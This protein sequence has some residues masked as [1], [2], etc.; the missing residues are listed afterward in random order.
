MIPVNQ[1]SRDGIRGLDEARLRSQVL[2]PL[3]EAMGFKGIHEYHGGSGEQGKDIIM[4]KEDELGERVY[5]GVV[6]LAERI[7]GKARG[8]TSPASKVEFQVRQSIGSSFQDLLTLK[9]QQIDRCWVVTSGEVKKEARESLNNSLGDPLRRLIRLIDGDELW[10]LVERYL[11]PHLLRSKIEEAH[12]IL[13]SVSDHYHI[14]AEV[15]GAVPVY[16]IRP[17]Y[18]GA[19]KKVPIIF[20]PQFEFP[21]TPE[22][23]EAYG[24]LKEHFRTGT[25]I[26]IAGKYISSFEVSDFLKPLMDPQGAGLHEL[27]MRYAGPSHTVSCEAVFEMP[28]GSVVSLP[29][30]ELQLTQAGSEEVTLS[31]AH[32]DLPYKFTI[33]VDTLRS[34]AA[35]TASL[36]PSGENVKQ[37]LEVVRFHQ[38]IAHGGNLRFIHLQT[39]QTLLGGPVAPQ[40]IAGPDEGLIEALEQLLIIQQRTSQLFSLP[41][42]I[43]AEEIE[44]IVSF[45]QIVSTGELTWE[46]G[47]TLAFQGNRELA[48]NTLAHCD[49]DPNSLFY[50]KGQDPREEEFFGSVLDLGRSVLRA[51]GVFVPEEEAVRLRAELADPTKKLFIIRVQV[52]ARTRLTLSYPK[53]LPELERQ[54]L[55]STFDI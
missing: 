32:Q 41:P 9:T 39:G 17:K 1:F 48:A 31:N 42:A 46:D 26:T 18:A 27:R 36:R 33:T 14:V 11:K 34:H 4:W 49:G 44:R 8:G 19:E 13:G 40:T 37:Q 21:D 38:A 20:R 53:W 52:P 51:Y 5:Y 35:L 15:G 47:V 2:I 6:V 29:G 43:S 55:Q 50:M 54:R 22:G 3:F 16:T 30:I 45:A 10:S 25:P 12:K 28:D 24:A 7:T 23:Q